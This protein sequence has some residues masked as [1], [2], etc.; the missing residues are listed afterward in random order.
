MTPLHQHPFFTQCPMCG[1]VL[2]RRMVPIVRHLSGHPAGELLRYA[3][4]ALARK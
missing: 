3:R 4:R 1:G 2:A